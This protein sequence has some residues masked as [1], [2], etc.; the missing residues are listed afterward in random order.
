MS[1]R[2]LAESLPGLA[3]D[4]RDSYQ[5]LAQGSFAFANCFERELEHGLEQA[6]SGIVNAK[7][8]GVDAHRNSPGAGFAVITGEGSLATFIE[9]A[10]GVER[11]WMGRDYEALQQR[12]VC[13]F[14]H[15]GTG[16]H[17]SEPS[18]GDFELRRLVERRSIVLHPVGDPPQ[19]G[20]KGNFGAAEQSVAERCIAQESVVGFFAPEHGLA[21]E[22]AAVEFRHL[23]LKSSPGRSRS[24][25]WA[26]KRRASASGGRRNWH[27][28]ARWH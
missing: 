20:F 11:Q 4:S 2:G 6:H 21:L 25:P 19:Q 16:R 26:G 18:V 17:G 27:L 8:R 15:R 23:A 22:S 7:L 24:R 28:L 13:L 5:A 3:A 9:F 14:I 10:I 12:R 1:E